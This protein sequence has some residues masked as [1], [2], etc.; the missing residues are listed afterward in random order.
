MR[1]QARSSVYGQ[2]RSRLVS[3]DTGSAPTSYSV[4]YTYDGA[5]R[6]VSTVDS[7]NSCPAYTYDADTN[8]TLLTVNAVRSDGS[9]G[10]QVAS[11][12]YTYDQ[13][14]RLTSA[15]TTYDALGRTTSVPSVVDGSGVASPALTLSYDAIDHVSGE[16]VAGVQRSYTTDSSGRYAGWGSASSTT[17][18]HYAGSSDAA[19]WSTEPGGA[20]VAN[21]QGLDGALAQTSSVAGTTIDLASLH[22]DVLATDA[23]SS[24]PMVADTLSVGVQYAPTGEPVGV[25]ATGNPAT[26]LPR[27]GFKG[28]ALRVT[29]S[30]S[31]LVL[32]GAWLYDPQ[33]GRFLSVDPVDG[34]SASAYDYCGA[35]PVNCEDLEGL[36]R[37]G[38]T[39]HEAQFDQYFARTHHFRMRWRVRMHWCVSD[40]TH[41]VTGEPRVVLND[42]S[43]SLA[44]FLGWA[45]VREELTD[46]VIPDGAAG[47]TFDFMKGFRRVA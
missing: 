20:A 12:A 34:G 30:Q 45:I 14:D 4:G 13:A 9:C 44:L 19:A 32:M 36:S 28:A 24:D 41:M 35:D 47:W 15:G 43:A 42:H 26:P 22:G 8:R 27:Y 21:V 33:L 39:C 46:Q 17:T 23:V 1:E 40:R 37:N 7:G 3:L 18:E 25:G 31:G 29:D 5:G 11:Q 38:V 2:W 10:V 16:T 6:L